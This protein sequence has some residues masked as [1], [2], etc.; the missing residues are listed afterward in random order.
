MVSHTS[1]KFQSVTAGEYAPA[2]DV[3]LPGEAHPA[4]VEFRRWLAAMGSPTPAQLAE[5]GYVAPHWPPPWG[6]GADAVT[7]LVID[8]ELRHAGIRRPFNPIGIGWAGPTIVHAG[9]EEQRRRFLP[10]L[11]S[12]EEVWCQLF[13]EPDAGSDLA[14]LSTRARRDGEDWVVEGHKVWTS[15]AHLARWGILLARTGPPESERHAGISYFLCPMDAPGV[16]VRPIVDMTGTHTFNE[17]ILDGLHLDAGL[18]VGAA[19][20]GWELAKVT[21]GNERVSLSGEGALWGQ[22]PTATDLVDLVRRRRLPLGPVTRDDL[23][24]VWIEGEVLRILRLRSLGA[25]MAGRPPGPETSVRKALADAHGQH[26]MAVG[27][28]VT[29]PASMVRGRGPDEAGDR[30][31]AESGWG[32]GSM[33]A[34]ALTIG[35]GTA[36]VQRNIIGERVLGLPHDP[37]PSAPGR[38]TRPGG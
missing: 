23:A 21:L 26:V 19:G 38:R 12:G 28:A 2:M 24:R 20:R 1:A 30:D 14:A 29:G 11:L 33:F 35:G 32:F 37:P 3:V 7:Q 10:P 13:S 34:P 36:E 16:S 27:A 8:D 22:G 5:A 4:R 17:V 25:A 18:L 15:Y 31:R 6:R 9:S